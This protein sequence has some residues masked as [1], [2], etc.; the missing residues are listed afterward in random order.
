M[1][2]ICNSLHF[3]VNLDDMAIFINP[4]SGND[5]QVKL[6]WGR[7]L[8]P[9]TL[10]RLLITRQGQCRIAG[11]ATTITSLHK[12]N[13]HTESH[14]AGHISVINHHYDFIFLHSQKAQINIAEKHIKTYF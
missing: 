1:D 14:M 8:W 3:W 6:A 13:N 10:L 2:L 12:N 9:L 4:K 5:I 11:E 7:G